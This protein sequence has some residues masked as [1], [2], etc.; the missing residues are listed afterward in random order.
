MRRVSWEV[1]PN[2]AGWALREEMLSSEGLSE[3]LVQ[4]V[5]SLVFM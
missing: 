2:P 1:A 3:A 5:A 4:E